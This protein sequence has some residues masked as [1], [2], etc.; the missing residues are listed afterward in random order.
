MRSL[1]FL[2]RAIIPVYDRSLNLTNATVSPGGDRVY[3]QVGATQYTLS[4]TKDGTGTGTV[5]AQSIPGGI[6]CGTVCSL[7]YVAG[8]EIRLVATPDPGSLLT[9]WSGGGCSGYGDCIVTLNA[10]TTVNATFTAFTKI[11]VL[12]PSKGEMIPAG[13]TYTIRWGAPANAVTFRIRYSL[14]NGTTWTTIASGVV[15]NSYIWSVPVPLKTR[16]N[17]RIRIIGFNAKGKRIGAGN[18]AKFT[19]SVP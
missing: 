15:G 1:P 7:A 18:S 12:L 8:T 19:I 13:S 5:S 17:C 3:L 10:N 6:D 11:T 4:V 14:N 9:A 16:T 2:K